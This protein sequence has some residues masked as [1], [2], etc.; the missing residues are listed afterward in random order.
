MSSQDQVSEP[1]GVQVV[2]TSDQQGGVKTPKMLEAE[3]RKRN[4]MFANVGSIGFA[5]FCILWNRIYDSMEIIFAQHLFNL[6]LDSSIILAGILGGIAI[7]FS[8]P[9]GLK[10]YYISMIFFQIGY[11]ANIIFFSINP[12]SQDE[13]NLR[14]NVRQDMEAGEEDDG[15]R[16]H[17]FDFAP[18]SEFDVKLQG[19]VMHVTVFF[20]RLIFLL[21]LKKY[22]TEFNSRQMKVEVEENSRGNNGDETVADQAV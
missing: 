9:L 16:N 13:L 14:N 4:M 20:V 18:V 5:G 15:L 10:I 1:E 17:L 6:S 12:A 3:H 11:L 8:K 22:F 19:A 7:W 2:Q 21:I